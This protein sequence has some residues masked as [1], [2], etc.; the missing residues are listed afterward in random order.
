LSSESNP[1]GNYLLSALPPEE[2]RRLINQAEKIPFDRDCVFYEADMPIRHV[3]FPIEGLV[4][5]VTPLEEGEIVEVLVVGR[6]GMVGLGSLDSPDYTV[7]TR[8]VGQIAGHALKFNANIMREEFNRAGRLHKNLLH[9]IQ[10]VMVQTGLNVA[11]NRMHELEARLAKWLL[12]VRDRQNSNSFTLT[13]DFLAQM[14]GAR[15]SSVTLAAGAL[16]R[17]SLINYHRGK[18]EIIADEELQQVSC[19]CYPAIRKSWDRLLKF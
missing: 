17:A 19:E 7:P 13:H 1:V 11:C 5:I 15:R 10:F 3:Y 14:L 6:E 12:M 4:S 8:A 16:Q 18:I 2:Y 9:Y